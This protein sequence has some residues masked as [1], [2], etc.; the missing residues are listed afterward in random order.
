M[1]ELVPGSA[2]E[3][4]SGSI[5][6]YHSV[7]FDEL[8]ELVARPS[9]A[10]AGGSVAA[11]VATFAA[12]LAVMTARLAADH[13]GAAGAAVAQAEALRARL[14]PLAREDA[15]A[16]LKALERMRPGTEGETGRD[17]GIAAALTQAAGVPLRIAEAA[18]DVA[19][20]A[21]DIACL[22]NPAVAADAVAAVLLA[23]ASAEAAAHIVSVNLGVTS[24]D[25]LSHRAGR[26]V[27][28]AEA[29]SHRAFAAGQ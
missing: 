18:A 6:D 29:A 2:G 8:I 25:E 15:A 3:E 11:L 21:A 27:E 5:V 16:Y 17:A 14:A 23:R 28:A 24:D 1:A 7:R 20:L 9:P 10:P 13:W 4:D 19:E 12:A 26:A 22:G